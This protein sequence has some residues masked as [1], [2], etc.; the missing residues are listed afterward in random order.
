MREERRDACGRT[1]AVTREG[2]FGTNPCG[3]GAY[4]LAE[5]EERRQD[6]TKSGDGLDRVDDRVDHKQTDGDHL[7]IVASAR[8]G[9]SAD[10]KPVEHVSDQE[11][12][13]DL[14]EEEEQGT[15]EEQGEQRANDLEEEGHSVHADEAFLRDSRHD[16]THDSRRRHAIYKRGGA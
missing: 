2:S 3:V 14:K 1:D 7:V 13:N 16:R 11:S 4:R 10:D 6:Q 12:V 15:A 9:H 5:E 8:S